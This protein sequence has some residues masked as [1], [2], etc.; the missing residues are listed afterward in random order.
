[1]EFTDEEVEAVKVLM[2]LA[3]D[4]SETANT[5][6]YVEYGPFDKGSLKPTTKS[7]YK[8]SQKI[9]CKNIEW[10]IVVPEEPIIINPNKSVHKQINH[11]NTL[12]RDSLNKELR[13][14][15]NEMEVKDNAES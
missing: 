14:A 6:G 9:K 10:N 8:L 5:F 1:M 3:Y 7:L 13:N 11:W 15:L 2:A 4:F 12:E